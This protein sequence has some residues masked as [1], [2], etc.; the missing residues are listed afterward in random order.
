MVVVSKTRRLHSGWR[1]CRAKGTASCSA[2]NS[3]ASPLLPTTALLALLAGD[4]RRQLFDPY[5]STNLLE[6]PDINETGRA[7]YTLRWEREIEGG[8]LE[9]GANYRAEVFLNSER[10]EPT[11]PFGGLWARNRYSLGKKGGLVG[12]IVEPPDHVG[13][14]VPGQGGDHELAKDVSAQFLLGWDWAAA[15]PDRST[16]F[17]GAVEHVDSQVILVDAAILTKAII[18]DDDDPARTTVELT[19]TASFAAANKDDA[20]SCG[21]IAVSVDGRPVAAKW[22]VSSS[23]GDFGDFSVDFRL[24]NAALW[25]PRGVSENL[26]PTLHDAAFDACDCRCY[27]A[28]GEDASSMK[29][30]TTTT[31]VAFRF[32]IRR[33]ETYVDE[34]TEGRAFKVNGMKFFLAGGNWIATDAMWR[35]S[36]DPD[37]Y[38]AELGTHAAAGLNAIRVWGG[39]V[40]ETDDFYRA[41]DELGLVVYQE[42]GFTGDNNGRWAGSYDWPLCQEAAA[43][44]IS[45]IAKRLRKFASIFLFGGGNEL[46]PSSKSPPDFAKRAIDD[47]DISSFACYIP[48]SMDGGLTGGDQADHR[49]AYALAPKDGP[50]GMLSPRDWSRRNPGLSPENNDDDLIVSVQPEIGSCA[51]PNSKRAL[52]KFITEEDAE[53]IVV[54]N[55]DSSEEARIHKVTNAAW[56]FHRYEEMRRVGDDDYDFVAA[57]DFF[58]P[59]NNGFFSVDEWLLA[60]N[61]ALHQQTQLLFESFASH[62]FDWYAGVFL[63]KSQS[64]WPALR[65][66]LYDWYFLEPNGNWRG[67]RAALSTLRAA[68]FD[69]DTKEIRLVNRDAKDVW[70]VSPKKKVITYE[71]IDLSKGVV[72]AG[73][74]DGAPRVEPLSARVVGSLEEDLKIWP[75]NA[76]TTCFLR[77]LGPPPVSN[78]YWVASNSQARPDYSAIGAARRRKRATAHVTLASCEGGGSSSLGVDVD[79]PASSEEVLFYPQFTLLLDEEG[80]FTSSSLLPSDW[81]RPLFLVRGENEHRLVLPGTTARYEL[82]FFFTSSQRRRRREKR[83]RSW[84]LVVDAVNLKEPIRLPLPL[85]CGGGGFFTDVPSSLF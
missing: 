35:Y 1:V 69:F 29:T 84:S 34:A 9:F 7:Y 71:W 12:I 4:P 19:A 83:I 47:A 58:P 24:S 45:A 5:N 21:E 39:G 55:D 42:F 61:L 62:L 51:V 53:A 41:A 14:P 57:Y 43:F 78:V 54:R 13:S 74:L 67:A 33:F 85:D 22:N 52:R 16:G 76:T 77:L 38:R 10:L 15:I 70:V 66:F 68:T 8:W 27:R 59:Q 72:R 23:E 37:R 80:D 30:L 25:W 82:V 11:T 31:R 28:A 48:S 81:Q 63:W 32:G 18:W 26:K 44:G 49:D 40:A 79:V 56:V 20:C 75:C 60:A 2:N 46:Y 50:Y 65:G 36:A 3:W 17:F 73:V 6:L 64:P